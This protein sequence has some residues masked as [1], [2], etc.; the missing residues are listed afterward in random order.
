MLK[1]K[2]DKL[3]KD[4]YRISSV[5]IQANMHLINPG[6]NKIIVSKNK[7]FIPYL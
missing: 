2:I 3:L 5:E 4:Y 6:G 1:E 7:S